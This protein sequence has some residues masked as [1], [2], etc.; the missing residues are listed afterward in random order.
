VGQQQEEIEQHLAS[1]QYQHHQLQQQHEQQQQ[2]VQQGL[3]PA[4]AAE[5]QYQRDMDEA[6]RLVMQQGQQQQQQQQEEYE[7]P[8]YIKEFFERERQQQQQQQQQGQHSQPHQQQD[9]SPIL[10]QDAG[11]QLGQ[12][13]HELHRIQE[14]YSSFTPPGEQLHQEHL[15]KRAA[16]APTPA[17]PIR[18]VVH[19]YAHATGASKAAV[20]SS[21]SSR[22]SQPSIGALALGQ[23]SYTEYRQVLSSR[24]DSPAMHIEARHK[25]VR[26]GGAHR[27]AIMCDCL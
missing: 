23:N 4:E 2:Q 20:M 26:A 24:K 14:S 22:G 13:H 15:A 27:C 6:E 10:Q 25:Q 11:K 16:A 18:P 12:P 3:S 8:W 21:S 5:L 9:P 7:Q 17:A 1:Q 19:M